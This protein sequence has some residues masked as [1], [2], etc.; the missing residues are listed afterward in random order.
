V[1][2]QISMFHRQLIHWLEINFNLL[3][4]GKMV[5]PVNKKPFFAHNAFVKN[6]NDTGVECEGEKG[7]IQAQISS[8]EFIDNCLSQPHYYRRI[9]LLYLN[10]KK[11]CT[12]HTINVYY[13]TELKQ[14]EIHLRRSFNPP[15]DVESFDFSIWVDPDPSV[16]SYSTPTEED[17]K[18][19]VVGNEWLTNFMEKYDTRNLESFLVNFVLYDNNTESF[20]TI[21]RYESINQIVQKIKSFKL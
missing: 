14:V 6:V 2:W 16:E 12:E 20:K 18:N 5:R 1:N 15:S 9:R 11:D 17:W 3:I 8:N 21:H 13:N 19:W 10:F 4:K 7:I